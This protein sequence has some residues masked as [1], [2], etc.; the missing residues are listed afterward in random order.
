MSYY[1]A[2]TAA[3]NT[4]SAQAAALPA[5]VAGTSLFG[6]TT[7]NKITA[8]NGWTVTGTVP[9][10]FNISGAQILGCINWTEFA[11]LT[12]AQQSNLLLLGQTQNLVGG[13]ATTAHIAAGMIL[14]YFS[15]GGATVAALTALASAQVQPW[16]STSVANGGGGLSSP[17]SQSDVT[18]A[19]GI[20]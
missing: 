17:I 19:G 4:S 5:G 9:T 15:L 13:T 1:S 6:L 3:W 12:A 16:W 11:A 20:S 2:L 10:T 14:A 8:V 18:A 7:A